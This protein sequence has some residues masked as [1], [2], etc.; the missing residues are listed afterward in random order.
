[1]GGCDCSNFSCDYFSDNELDELVRNSKIFDFVPNNA[2]EYDLIPSNVRNGSPPPLVEEEDFCLEPPEVEELKARLWSEA[3]NFISSGQA[4]W[5]VSIY[6]LS[7]KYPWDHGTKNCEWISDIGKLEPSGKQCKHRVRFVKG[8]VR[9]LDY[10]PPETL[11][12]RLRARFK[13]YDGSCVIC[14]SLWD[15][16]LEKRAI[17]GGIIRE[18]CVLVLYDVP[19]LFKNQGVPCYQLSIGY[20]NILAVFN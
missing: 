19:V 16:S 2:P 3:C 18:N 5:K 14:V 17:S 20:S 10:D 6:H 8:F 12:M 11:P 1:M 15:D 13:L 7:Y 4:E 9:S